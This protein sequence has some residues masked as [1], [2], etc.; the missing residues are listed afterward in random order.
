M[1]RNLGQRN[2]L[3]ETPTI[4]I[5]AKTHRTYTPTVGLI[6]NCGLGKVMD[7]MSM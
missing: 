3:Y 6:V 7:D 5:F 1:Q 2:Y 4:G